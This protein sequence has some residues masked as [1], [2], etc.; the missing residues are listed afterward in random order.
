MEALDSLGIDWKLFIAQVINFI[1]LLLV[2][3]KFLYGPIVSML[4]DRKKKIEQGLKDNEEARAKLEATNA[5]TRKLLTEAS[6][7]SEKIIKA[8]KK[9]ME[10]ETKKKLSEAQKKGRG[11]IEQFQK[12][13]R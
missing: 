3:W 8:A 1:V 7:E 10:E 6:L 12:N 4:S 13:C 11:N 2:L 9:E 5:E